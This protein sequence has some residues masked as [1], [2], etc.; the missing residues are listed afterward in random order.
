MNGA[1]KLGDRAS[2]AGMGLG[3]ALLFLPLGS[4][5]FREGPR[6]CGQSDAVDCANAN[7]NSSRTVTP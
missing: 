4:A 2:L 5:A 6:H 1:A 3:L 7:R